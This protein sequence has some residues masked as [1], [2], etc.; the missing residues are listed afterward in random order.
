MPPRAARRSCV[1]PSAA[2][3][4]DLQD[5][6]RGCAM[7][8]SLVSLIAVACAGVALAAESPQEAFARAWEGRHVTVKSTL[9]SLIYTERGK[10]GTTHSGLREGVIVIT[11]SQ[12][13]YFQFDGRQG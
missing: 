3:I 9:Y 13:A 5:R 2:R 11:P 1:Q 10:L 6:L 12:G 7:K 8:R 4:P